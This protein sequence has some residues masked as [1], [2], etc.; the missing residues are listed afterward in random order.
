MQKIITRW[1]ARTRAYAIHATT[2]KPKLPNY[3]ANKTAANELAESNKELQDEL[4]TAKTDLADLQKAHDELE[5]NADLTQLDVERLTEENRWLTSD[6]AKAQS[7]AVVN[8][9]S[10]RIM[11]RQGSRPNQGGNV[12]PWQ[13]SSLYPF[14][15]EKGATMSPVI[16]LESLVLYS[17]KH[18]AE[19]KKMCVMEAVAFVANKPSSDHPVCAPARLFPIS[20]ANGMTI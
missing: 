11:C 17:G 15:N 14:A 7:M 9:P 1:N 2:W 18:D 10:R 16:Q 6:L 20:C 13:A 3:V 4:D 12:S 5:A 8:R 19:S